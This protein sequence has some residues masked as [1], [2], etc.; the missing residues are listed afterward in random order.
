MAKSA[1]SLTEGSLPRQILL[2]SLPLIASNL[3]QVMFNM[4]DI[5]VIGQF[6]GTA[7]LGSVGSTTTLVNIF[8]GTLLGFGGGI[9]VLA[10]R[11]LGARDWKDLHETTHT[12][13]V[14]SLLL[15]LF[16]LVFGEAFSPLFLRL[17]GTK[18]ELLGGAVLYMRV[19]LLSMPGAALYNFGNA[20]FSAAGNTRKPLQYL[21]AAGILNIV[22][23][24][25]F[26][27]VLK[28]DVAGVA[29]ASAVSQTFSGTML[30]RALICTK[31]EYGVQPRKIRMTR[32]KVS[33]LLWLCL[34]AAFQNTVFYTSSLF[35]Q[36][37]INSFDATMVAANAAAAN[38]DPLAYDVMAAFH[39]A[40]AS[41]VGQNY[42][43]GNKERIRK[44]YHISL[45]YSFGVSAC[46]STLLLLFHNQFLGIFTS[47]PAVVQAGLTR[48]FVMGLSYPWSAFMDCTIAA[49]RG[50]GKTVGPT[51]IVILGSCVFR[52]V[53]VYTIFAFFGTIVSLYLLYIVSWAITAFFEI[54]S[55][56]RS[57]REQT[58]IFAR[59]KVAVQV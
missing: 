29:A 54:L 57:F 38:A 1:S 56:R 52:I 12:A 11:Y 36:A 53:W 8:T 47:D 21:T 25:F 20:M 49:S 18:A 50:L 6:S 26:V 19:Y 7:A 10:A 3:L 40:C 55:Y 13:L 4:A 31:D 43:A 14:L 9:S 46:I 48:L 5:A 32:N 16:A 42:G 30:L 51:V 37:G 33:P 23:N 15:G 17:L 59:E 34:P 45:A 2:Y 28:W 24:L 35:V 41:F 39:T 22:L 44:S 27:V 58:K